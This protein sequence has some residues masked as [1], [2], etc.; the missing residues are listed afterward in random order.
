MPRPVHTDHAP[1]PAG[2]YSQAIVHAGLVHVAGQLALDP[3]TGA[4][5][6]ESAEEQADRTLRNIEAILR[7]AG[8]DLGL[9]LSLTVFVRSREDWPGVNAACARRFGPHRP[10]RAIVGGAE[11]KP[12][13]LVEMTAVA[14]IRE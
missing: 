12:G 1:R 6:G 10:A 2:H 9:V 13:C 8:S 7:A 4:V 14:A 11:L 3:D 5:V